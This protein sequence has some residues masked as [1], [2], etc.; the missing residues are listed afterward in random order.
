MN[1]TKHLQH[2]RQPHMTKDFLIQTSIVPRLRYPAPAI[3]TL[4]FSKHG[5]LSHKLLHFYT[6][7]VSFTWNALPCFCAQEMTM[8]H[9]DQLEMSLLLY[10]PSRF[11]KERCFFCVSPASGTHLTPVPGPPKLSITPKGRTSAPFIIFSP[12]CPSGTITACGVIN[13]GINASVARPR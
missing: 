3:Q 10:A 9:T 5:R 2:R 8:W 1:A 12:K 11:L 4:L 7:A 13:Q 6:Q